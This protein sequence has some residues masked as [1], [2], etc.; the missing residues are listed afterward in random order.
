MIKTYDIS[1][2]PEFCG[3]THSS[4]ILFLDA[5]VH[6]QVFLYTAEFHI[7]TSGFVPF[8]YNLDTYFNLLQNISL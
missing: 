3:M 4:A 1:K 6:T 8:L 5:L 7:E 2:V